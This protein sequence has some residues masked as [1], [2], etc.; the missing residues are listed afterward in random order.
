MILINPVRSQISLGISLRLLP[1]FPIGQVAFS[2]EARLNPNEQRIFTFPPS[3]A[4]LHYGA[5]A[6]DFS[7]FASIRAT[8]LCFAKHQQRNQT[9]CQQRVSDRG[10]KADV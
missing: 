7:G 1:D 2:H 10:A 6:H 8:Q 5:R 3:F 9:H 4:R